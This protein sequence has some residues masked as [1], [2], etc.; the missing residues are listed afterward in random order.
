MKRKVDFLLIAS[1]VIVSAIYFILDK[2]NPKSLETSIPMAEDLFFNEL[3]EIEIKGSFKHQLFLE[4]VDAFWYWKDQQQKAQLANPVKAI[5]IFKSIE[6]KEKIEASK[7]PTEFFAAAEYYKFTDSANKTIQFLVSNKKSVTGDLF[8]KRIFGN[9]IDYFL[10]AEDQERSLRPKIVDWI[11]NTI[12]LE[13]LKALSKIEIESKETTRMWLREGSE[14]AFFY[15]NKKLLSVPESLFLKQLE[16]T[17]MFEAYPLGN[18]SSVELL[19]YGFDSDLAT[20]QKIHLEFTDSKRIA[21]SRSYHK[22]YSN[23]L[24]YPERSLMINSL[25]SDLRIL[26]GNPVGFLDL[27]E[28]HHLSIES[29]EKVN[30]HIKGKERKSHFYKDPY[31]TNGNKKSKLKDWTKQLYRMHPDSLYWQTL[32]KKADLTLEFYDKAK[33]KKA[34]K[35]YYIEEYLILHRQGKDYSLN[36]SQISKHYLKALTA[37]CRGEFYESN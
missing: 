37:L 5:S 19:S 33:A 8:L 34:L 2:K 26:H 22:D 6:L 10:V 4:K 18:F 21:L 14:F 9:K 16:S 35:F 11:G 29:I 20:N 24:V 7:V 3:K 1:L 27:G 28:Y 12:F 13:S 32:P 15:G 17:P 23:F 30:C 36:L 31:L 25:A